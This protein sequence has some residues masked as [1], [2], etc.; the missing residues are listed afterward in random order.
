[1]NSDAVAGP[2]EMLQHAQ[3]GH[4]HFHL[5]GQTNP[6]MW[7][8]TPPHSE[9]A[10]GWA[11]A[12]LLP[13]TNPVP[14]LLHV[15]WRRFWETWWG[16][17]QARGKRAGAMQRVSQECCCQMQLKRHRGSLYPWACKRGPVV[18]SAL[19]LGS[20]P[21]RPWPWWDTVPAAAAVILN[22]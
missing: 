9:H 6:H 15:C 21:V 11:K 10:G 1:M 19:P 4:P 3:G 7:P 2:S 20:V 12:L 5:R 17:T 8:N 18:M 16:Y 14:G 13:F 22:S